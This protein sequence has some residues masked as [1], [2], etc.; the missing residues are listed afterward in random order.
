M[1]MFEARGTSVRCQWIM[2]AMALSFLLVV[3]ATGNAQSPP[4]VATCPA[5]SASPTVAPS[6]TTPSTGSLSPAPEQIV[7][8][9]GAQSITGATFSHWGDVERRAGGKH[10]PPAEEKKKEVMG[11]LVSSDWVLGEAA[12]LNIDV[13]EAKVRH[14]FNHLRGE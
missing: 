7:A 6:S 12:D 13:S 2:G 4:P 8:C 5:P 11:F 1:P 9:I 10:P 3:V 14:T